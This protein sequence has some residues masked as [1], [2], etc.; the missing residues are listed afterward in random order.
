[1]CGPPLNLFKSTKSFTHP[2]K[3]KNKKE[4]TVNEKGNKYIFFL[5]SLL[6]CIP[7]NS[8][9]LKPGSNRLCWTFGHF[10]CVNITFHNLI[11]PF[12]IRVFPVTLVAA[13]SWHPFVL[14]LSTHIHTCIYFI[15]ASAFGFLFLLFRLQLF[16]YMATRFTYL[17][18]FPVWRIFIAHFFLRWQCR[19]LS[20]FIWCVLGLL[21][22][23][24]FSVVK[25]DIWVYKKL[26]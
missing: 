22:W 24:S 21:I 14:Y 18:W 2:K 16:F 19:W 15:L 10:G 25:R 8:L 13:E 9:W 4:I 3:Y 1:M 5:V 7:F 20:S 26:K 12:F 6:A 17:I 11:F 23:A